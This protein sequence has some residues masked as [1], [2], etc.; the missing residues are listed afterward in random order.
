MLNV[1]TSFSRF[2]YILSWYLNFFLMNPLP[3]HP[4]PLGIFTHFFFFKHI[5]SYSQEGNS[6]SSVFLSCFPNTDITTSKQ[7]PHLGTFELIINI[8]IILSA[9]YQSRGK[10]LR[11]LHV[12]I[13]LLLGN[14][15]YY[16]AHF[17]S[18]DSE[19]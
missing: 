18:V 12:L 16:C 3:F 4:T 14:N 2:V 6:C 19:V 7:S 5:L 9:W 17:V 8:I 10:S 13:H 1:F 11:T 15:Y